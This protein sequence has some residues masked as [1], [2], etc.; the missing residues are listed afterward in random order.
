VEIETAPERGT[1]VVLV[2][3]AAVE[4]AE[5][6]SH[7]RTALLSLGDERLQSFARS[8]LTALGFHVSERGRVDELKPTLWLTDQANGRDIRQAIETHL[9]EWVMLLGHDPD[10][11][12]IAHLIELGSSPRPTLLQEKL[13][14][15][16]HSAGPALGDRTRL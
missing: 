11:A 9:A 12:G 6:A 14:E 4:P 16:A 3:P 15:V 1:R 7:Q 8:V 2:L 5:Q 10:A 13:R